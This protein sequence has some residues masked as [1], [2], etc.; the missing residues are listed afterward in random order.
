MQCYCGSAKPF[1]LCCHAFISGQMQV[2]YC[3]QLMRSRYSAYCHKAVDYIYQTYHPSVRQENPVAA[4]ASFAH[5]SHFITLEVHSAEQ[6]A[7]EGFVE[8]TVKYMQHNQLH[9][10]RERSRFVLED[11]WY[12][13]NGIL[14]EQTPWKIQ[15][16]EQC[17]CNSRKK[18][19]Q[20]RQHLISGSQT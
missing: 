14:I 12:Y 4:L 17:P 7:K 3:E 9:Q 8:F 10:F 13:L 18:F 11:R 2:R 6:S 19:K 16:N 5:D 20:C 1:D 15:R